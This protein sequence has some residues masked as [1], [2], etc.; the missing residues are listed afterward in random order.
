MENSRNRHYIQNEAARQKK[1]RKKAIADTSTK[2]YS[3]PQT[4][5]M[6]E[7]AFEIAKK[8]ELDK[9]KTDQLNRDMILTSTYGQKLN[10]KWLESRVKIINCSYFGR[11]INARSP[12]TYTTLLYEM[13]Y[14]GRE[15]GNTAELKHQRLYET[16]AL[17]MFSLVHNDYDLQKT[18]LFIDKDCS[19]IGFIIHDMFNLKTPTI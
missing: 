15:F 13:L 11:I 7:H 9:L 2:G 12:K 19:Y 4:L 16:E 3:D 14:T 17:K 6:S 10:L 5:D 8:I 1:P 18:G